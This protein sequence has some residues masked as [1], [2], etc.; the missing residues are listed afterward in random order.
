MRANNHF[1]AA[2]FLLGSWHLV[3]WGAA[4]P[5][6]SSRVLCQNGRAQSYLS[7]SRRTNLGIS[8]FSALVAWLVI[9][10]SLPAALSE[11]VMWLIFGFAVVVA[12]VFLIAGLLNVTWSSGG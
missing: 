6:G 8:A 4:F 5:F 3:H 11:G 7:G 10:G 12:V 2:R 9:S 1:A